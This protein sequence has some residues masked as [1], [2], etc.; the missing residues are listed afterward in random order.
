MQ[1]SPQRLDWR[2][3]VAFAALVV[4]LG[5]NF[6]AVRFSNRELAPF[7]GAALRFMIASAILFTVSFAFKLKL[8]SGRGL[9]GAVLYGVLAFGAGFALVYWGLV[10]VPAAMGSIAFATIPVTT[11]VL[12][13]LVGL[14]RFRWRGALGALVT[15]VGISLIFSEQLAAEVP[16]VPLLVV[17]IAAVTAAAS[18][19]VIKWFPRSHPVG[20]NAVAMA[21]G[22]GILIVVSLLVRETPRL[23]SLAPTWAALGWLVASSVVAFVLLV[24]VITKWTASAASYSSVLS[25]LVTFA[26]ASSLAGESITLPFLAGSLIVLAGVYVG[27]ISK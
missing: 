12:A 11:L 1:G 5:V 18:G 14:E 19:I 17:L 21:V 7:W 10:R 25:P 20:V 2:V 3:L 8:P 27:A 6:V 24:W 13:I 9:Q 26:V 4:F 22:S 23:P 16:P 15:L